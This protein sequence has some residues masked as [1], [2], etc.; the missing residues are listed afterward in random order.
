MA[1]ELD[2]AHSHVTFA[3]KHMMVSTTRGTF[4]NFTGTF[5]I[6]EQHPE[7]SSVSAEA[8]TA[9]ID[10]GNEQRDAH[11]RSADFFDAE[12]YPKITFKSTRVEEIGEREYTVIGDLTMHG[13]TRQ[14]T[15][16]AEYS[17]QI[18]DAFGKQRAGINAVTTINRKDFG[19][20]W[21]VALEAGGW[22]V[23]DTVKIELELEVTEAIPVH[24]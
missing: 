14:V 18:K 24:A 9:S 3:V 16:K 12:K 2:T 15:F 4:K 21:N 17:G 13:E 20:N 6:D 5:H 11:L 8:Y 7:L 10:T 19:L 23:S 22:M 1:W